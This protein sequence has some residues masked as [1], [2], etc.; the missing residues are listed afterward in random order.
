MAKTETKQEVKWYIAQVKN[1]DGE[2]ITG[3]PAPDDDTA[4]TLAFTACT[5]EVGDDGQCKVLDV[6]QVPD[7]EA[8][9]LSVLLNV[10]PAEAREM[11]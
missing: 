6:Q 8:L 4:R 5:V 3:G 10:T 2:Y 7:E 11:E 1:R 9:K